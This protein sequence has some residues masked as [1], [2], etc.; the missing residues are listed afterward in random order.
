VGLWRCEPFESKFVDLWIA[1]L[2]QVARWLSDA[3][4]GM[5]KAIAGRLRFGDFCRSFL[6]ERIFQIAARRTVSE[7]SHRETKQ[8][9]A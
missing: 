8:Q 7:P 6:Q 1:A 3:G 2:I 4:W 5:E 9:P